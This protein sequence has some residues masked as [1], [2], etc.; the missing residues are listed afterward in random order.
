LRRIRGYVNVEKSCMVL[1]KGTTTLG[2]PALR[3]RSR[4]RHDPP[5]VHVLRDAILS[6]GIPFQFHVGHRFVSFVERVQCFLVAL[7]D[8]FAKF[9]DAELCVLPGVPLQ[10]GTPKLVGL[11][12]SCKAIGG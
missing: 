9:F 12:G 5:G 6:P 8:E 10:G 3:F 4:G 2:E 11:D 7:A 1:K